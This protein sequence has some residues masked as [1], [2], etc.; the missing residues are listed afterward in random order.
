MSG[1]GGGVVLVPVAI[2]AIPVLAA[3]GIVYGM[4]QAGKAAHDVILEG[5]RRRAESERKRHKRLSNQVKQLV[6]D[7]QELGL[8]SISGATLPDGET[9][10][11]I[12]ASS[13]ASAMEKVND[14]LE[15]R[16]NAKAAEVAEEKRLVAKYEARIAAARTERDWLTRAASR[17][18]GDVPNI[19][20]ERSYTARKASERARL[21]AES[22]VQQNADYQTKVGER[23]REQR[24]KVEGPK[25]ADLY[26]QRAFS[27]FLASPDRRQLRLAA[28]RSAAEDKI[29]DALGALPSGVVVPESVQQQIQLLHEAEETPP[30]VL[31][32]V[33]KSLENAAATA[34]LRAESQERAAKVKVRAAN[35]GAYEYQAKSEDVLEHLAGLPA[36]AGWDARKAIELEYDAI[37][38]AVADREAELLATQARVLALTAFNEA[39]KKAGLEL[40]GRTELG[41][42]KPEGGQLKAQGSPLE[43]DEVLVRVRGT[44]KAVRVKTSNLVTDPGRVRFS[45]D[46]VWLGQRSEPSDMDREQHDT[47]CAAIDAAIKLLPECGVEVASLS[48][49]QAPYDPDIPV[50]ALGHELSALVEEEINQAAPAAR[51]DTQGHDNVRYACEPPA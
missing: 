5:Q 20:S 34:Q 17:L 10:S 49:Q 15:A 47:V 22:L 32:R 7:A 38:R 35:I 46:Q 29:A 19:E 31:R 11:I 25:F 40:S 23:F 43:P 9:S 1:G 13:W 8:D 3:A 44:R 45:V 24:A 30:A 21:L 6:Q 41:L 48:M 37:E 39:F 28:E 14:K 51:S 12:A 4:V 26:E 33:L 36:D 42:W 2:A 27:R 18:E 50:I 16:V